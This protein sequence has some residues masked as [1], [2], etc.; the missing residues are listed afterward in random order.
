MT[1]P[2]RRELAA[3]IAFITAITAALLVVRSGFAISSYPWVFPDSL[4]WIVNGLAYS[5]VPDV[6]INHRPILYPLVV[7]ALDRLGFLDASALFG[8]VGFFIGGVALAVLGGRAAPARVGLIATI[9]YATNAKVLAQSAVI[10]A[11]VVAAALIS[12]SALAFLRYLQTD[13]RGWFATAVLCGA[14]S[15]QAQYLIIVLLPI[16]IVFL[17]LAGPFPGQM[18]NRERV[19]RL[20]RDGFTWGVLSAG[21]GIV[22]LLLLPRILSYGIVYEERVA[23]LS[24]IVP[25]LEHVPFYLLTLPAFF[26]WPVITLALLGAV[27]GWSDPCS[28]LVTRFSLAWAAIIMAFFALLYSYV[29]IRFLIYT[30]APVF[31]LAGLGVA[32]RG[33]RLRNV[34]Y[35]RLGR[36]PLVAGALG[37][38]NLV[39]SDEPFNADIIISPS[40]LYAVDEDGLLSRHSR[41]LSWFI[42]VHARGTAD[43]RQVLRYRL[44][45]SIYI[46]HPLNALA[47]SIGRGP[48][49]RKKRIVIYDPLSPSEAYVARNRNIIYFNAPVVTATSRDELRNAIAAGAATIIARTTYSADF[50]DHARE[51]YRTVGP[52]SAFKVTQRSPEQRQESMPPP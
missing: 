17:L 35:A 30:A 1:N 40:R 15:S 32:H 8:T 31:M 7:A 25:S 13:A 27:W 2:D 39:V 22:G 26:S 37:L 11:D 50:P 36:V 18:L 33:A 20:I 51:P 28:R 12:V 24:L 10:G 21:L 48:R 49:A 38:A 3:S 47:R 16:F 29:A 23:H 46:S 42:P 34:G 52:W 45:D 5:S 6:T 44:I 19:R 41:E 4:D 14:I 43:Y 9:A